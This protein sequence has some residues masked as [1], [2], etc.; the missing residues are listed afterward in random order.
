MIVVDSL[1]FAYGDKQL[2]DGLS[3]SFGGVS[4]ITGLSGC[5]KTT[6]LRLLAGLEKPQSGTIA[7]VADR[8]SFMFQEDR[9]LPWSSA[10]ENVAAALSADEADN[11]ESWLKKVE[12]EDCLSSYPG[13][14]SGGQTRR[15]ALARAL[16]YRGG[17][18]ILD[19]PFKGFDP[20]LTRRM[21]GLILSQNVP[22]IAS[23]HSLE[24]I[25]L[26]GG[27]IIRLGEAT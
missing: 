4:C 2:F 5:G 26:L 16:A 6:L 3:L 21:A 8:V 13:N 10:R 25:G 20:E 14:M 27:D 15:V 19:E 11:A 1:S 23:V 7:G 17:V 12:L 24:E 18:L 9:L 22:V